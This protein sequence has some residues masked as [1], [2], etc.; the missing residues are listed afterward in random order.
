ME[1][2]QITFTVVTNVSYGYEGDW[3]IKV[4]ELR[5]TIK[6]TINK[7]GSFKILKIDSKEN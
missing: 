1:T 3:R 5:S 6:N 7:D 4:R 2:K